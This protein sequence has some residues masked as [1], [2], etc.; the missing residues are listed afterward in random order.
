[1]N[2]HFYR[3]GQLVPL[4]EKTYNLWC[5]KSKIQNLDL[6]PN[7]P[8]IPLRTLQSG[9]ATLTSIDSSSILKSTSY[10]SGDLKRSNLFYYY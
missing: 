8:D 5:S 4:Q 7:G 1:M 3:V 10:T 9:Y 2:I 6:A